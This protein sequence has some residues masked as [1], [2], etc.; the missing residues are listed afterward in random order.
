MCAD[1]TTRG[2]AFGSSLLGPYYRAFEV[3]IR[4]IGGVGA[5]VMADTEKHRENGT[6]KS[7]HITLCSV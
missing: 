6:K 1:W 4:W 5:F 3:L 2:A 7:A